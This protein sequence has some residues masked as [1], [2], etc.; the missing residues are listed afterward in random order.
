MVNEVRAKKLWRMLLR[1]ARENGVRVFLIP[2]AG[3]QWKGLYVFFRTMGEAIAIREDL[4][5][6]ERVWIL[7]HELGHRFAG[8]NHL[9]FSPFEERPAALV[10]AVGTSLQ[11]ER[12]RRRRD[13]DEEWADQW[14]ASAVIEPEDWDWAERGNPLDLFA[15]AGSLGLPVDAAIAWERRR[16]NAPHS[17]RPVPVAMEANEI[18]VLLAPM[19]GEGGHQ[20][21]LDR[22]GSSRMGRH[23]RVS[24][25][26]FSLARERLLTVRGGWRP[27]Y[28]AVLKATVRQ[29]RPAG[30]VKKFFGL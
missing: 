12:E 8:L 10:K 7:A 16:R 21:L 3:L 5:L 15:M 22:I 1:T 20:A 6:A 9:L 13:P 28:E 26:D 18:A 30:G 11:L 29:A 19:S 25:R 24:F 27:R 17:A 2:G 14:A 23:V 4:P